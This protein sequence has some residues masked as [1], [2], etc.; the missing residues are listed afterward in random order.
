MSIILS[1]TEERARDRRS[2]LELSPFV[3]FRS[4]HSKIVE[5]AS[6]TGVTLRTQIRGRANENGRPAR[7]LFATTDKEESLRLLPKVLRNRS[8]RQWR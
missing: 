4:F 6:D 8:G 7:D 5:E 1:I 3:Y 2:I